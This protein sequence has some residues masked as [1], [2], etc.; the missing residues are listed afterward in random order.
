[1]AE[2]P[3]N[4]WTIWPG[5]SGRFELERVDDLRRNTH[6]V[7]QRVGKVDRWT[8]SDQKHRW[9]ATVLLELEPR[10]RRLRGYRALPQLRAALQQSMMKG[11]DGL[12]A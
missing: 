3:W 1:V 4:Q 9:L 8:T 10:L 5:I 6:L 11:H 12:V 7:E 2:L